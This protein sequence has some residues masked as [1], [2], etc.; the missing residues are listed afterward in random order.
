MGYSKLI[1]MPKTTKEGLANFIQM[2]INQIE[3]GDTTE[4]V[5]TLVGLLDDVRGKANPY[6]IPNNH[7][8]KVRPNDNYRGTVNVD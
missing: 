7:K 2:A 6:G 5:Y 8:R 3:N 4:A 1:E